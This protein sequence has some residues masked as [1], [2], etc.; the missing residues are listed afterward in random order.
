M[1][2]SPVGW[3]PSRFPADRAEAD[4]AFTLAERL[5]SI[6]AAAAELGT[7]WPSVRKAFARH[8]TAT[9]AASPCTSRPE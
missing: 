8:A 7:N 1:P 3:Q 9:S 2:S 4:R 6:N 5:D